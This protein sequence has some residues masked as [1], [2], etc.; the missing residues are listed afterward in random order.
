MVLVRVGLPKSTGSLPIAC[1]NLEAPA[2]ISANSLWDMQRGRFREPGMAI[3]ELDVAL[4]SA[5]FVAMAHYGGYPWTVEQY[6]EL[7]G[8]HSWAWWAQMDFCC[9]PE[10]ADSQYTIDSRVWSSAYNL[11]YCRKVA[12]TWRRSGAYWLQDPMPVLQ[13]WAPKDYLHCIKLYDEVLEGNWPDLV[14]IGSVCRRKIKGE[15][16]LLAILKAVTEAL[17]QNVGFH[18]FGVKSGALPLFNPR[19]ISTDSA[20][21]QFRARMI[22][23]ENKEP[24]TIALK[25]E[26]MKYWYEKQLDSLKQMP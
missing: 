4:D 24:C 16:G 15:D 7:A 26:S 20:A 25:K 14:G 21:W 11:A 12:S 10:V 23:L 6:V 8:L 3:G 1:E 17:P 18:L 9:E 5:G 2:L 22:A 19:V 13:G